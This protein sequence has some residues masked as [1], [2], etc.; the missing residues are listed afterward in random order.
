M[1]KTSSPI[2]LF[3]KSNEVSILNTHK[4]ITVNRNGWVNIGFDH[5]INS[6]DVI[7]LDIVAKTTR[8]VPKGDFLN[9]CVGF[10]TKDV[11]HAIQNHLGVYIDGWCHC[12][13]GHVYSDAKQGKWIGNFWTNQAI[14]FKFQD[15]KI[16]MYVKGVEL[17]VFDVKYMFDRD[18]A[19]D[20]NQP[21]KSLILKCQ[22]VIANCDLYI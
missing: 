11:M 20:Q 2:K 13:N 19:M 15:Y 12:Q 4:L 14:R 3:T 7:T 9:F 17:D 18:S 10:G 5:V 8:S 6:G 1:I 16:T 22:T 21:L